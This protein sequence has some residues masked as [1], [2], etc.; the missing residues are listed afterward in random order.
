MGTIVPFDPTAIH[1]ALV[2]QLAELVDA[3]N[4]TMHLLRMSKEI[5]EM[6]KQIR[7]MGQE[8]CA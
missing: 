2:E 8:P 7:D 4:E 6:R 1:K 5:E 3:R